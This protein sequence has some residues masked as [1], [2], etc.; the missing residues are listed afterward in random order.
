MENVISS[1]EQSYFALTF[2]GQLHYLNDNSFCQLDS[3]EVYYFRRNGLYYGSDY[4]YLVNING[5][6]KILRVVTRN[7]ELKPETCIYGTHQVSDITLHPL[8][9]KL[10]MPLNKMFGPEY[11]ELSANELIDGAVD[12]PDLH[13][14][15]S[16]FE[17]KHTGTFRC[18]P[19]FYI[20]DCED[21]IQYL[22]EN[23]E[24]EMKV[25]SFVLG[26]QNDCKICNVVIG[27]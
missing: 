24:K 4:Y 2:E 13:L 6:I 26:E 8:A 21:R 22:Y 16:F 7:K 25:L 5:K 27:K 9:F 19:A 20:V 18:T 12:G 23:S 15:A 3:S 14:D 11:P 1:A 17:D 10:K